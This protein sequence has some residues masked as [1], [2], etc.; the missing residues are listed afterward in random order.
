MRLRLALPL[1]ALAACAPAAK[2][3]TAPAPTPTPAATPGPGTGWRAE[4][5]RGS[6]IEAAPPAAGGHALGYALVDTAGN[7]VFVTGADGTLD[8]VELATGARIFHS[9][10]AQGAIRLLGGGALA[11]LDAGGRVLL[12]DANDGTT[13]FASD[14]TGARAENVTAVSVGK[15]RL[16]VTWSLENVSHGGAEMP[17]SRTDG[18][19]TV[20][21]R[22]GLV[23]RKPSKVTQVGPIASKPPNVL[24]DWTVALVVDGGS[25]VSGFL[26]TTSLSISF[27]RGGQE[28]WRH[29]VPPMVQDFAPYP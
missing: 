27:S 4:H 13:L 10:E 11:A 21:L 16:R 25:S 29:P 3:A 20:N 22:T 15:E 9:K 2:R 5:R 18:A 1:L 7:R 17:P 24:G 12:L 6:I 28:I 19:F 8:A 23:D 14:P 26:R